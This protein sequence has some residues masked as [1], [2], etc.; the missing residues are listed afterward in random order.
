MQITPGHGLQAST[1]SPDDPSQHPSADVSSESVIHHPW[2]PQPCLA[3]LCE[4]CYVKLASFYLKTGTP[5]PLTPHTAPHSCLSGKQ[6]LLNLLY[7]FRFTHDIWMH[8]SFGRKWQNHSQHRTRMDQLRNSVMDLHSVNLAVIGF[9]P[10]VTHTQGKESLQSRT[11]VLRWGS[12]C[13]PG[14]TQQCLKLF[15][16]VLVG[17]AAATG[18]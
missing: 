13:P 18:F 10:L 14:H 15:G 5:H 16:D 4:N 3:P 2:G 12:F 1:D 7:L 11:V 17:R 9:W 8:F 6:N